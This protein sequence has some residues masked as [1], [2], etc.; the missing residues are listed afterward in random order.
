[1]VRRLFSH[2][3]FCS[4]VS[5]LATLIGGLKRLFSYFALGR[6]A[7]TSFQPFCFFNSGVI[8]LATLIGELKRLFSYFALDRY[9][10]ACF[11]HF[12]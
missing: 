12:A 4:G 10:Q 6:Y 11:S 1:M 9:A 5:L 7:Q 8:L 3:A 2:F